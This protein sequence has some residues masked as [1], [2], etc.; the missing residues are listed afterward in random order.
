M[1]SLV[2]VDLW[3]TSRISQ[4]ST[5]IFQSLCRLW[6][7]FRL[8]LALIINLR[9]LLSSLLMI[10]LLNQWEVWLEMN[11]VLTHSNRDTLSEVLKMFLAST[12]SPLEVRLTLKKLP[13]VWSNF[14]RTYSLN[15]QISEVSCSSVP[16]FLHI[17]M[18]WGSTLAN[19]FM[20]YHWLR[21]LPLRLYG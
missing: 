15:T 21:L 13:P 10:K 17:Q 2:I 12:P 4:E 9:K 18:L 20:M 8:L 16:N 1:E 19:Q 11:V 7:N 6:P 3:C 14:A 5:P